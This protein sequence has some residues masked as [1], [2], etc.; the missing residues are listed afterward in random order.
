M[1]DVQREIALLAGTAGVVFALFV[2]ALVVAT[3][4][5]GNAHAAHHC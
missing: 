4:I 1:Y 3:V 2:A 5:A